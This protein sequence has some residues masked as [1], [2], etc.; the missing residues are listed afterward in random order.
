MPAMRILNSVGLEVELPMILEDDNKGAVDICNSWT[1]G[2]RTHHM[3]KSR[4]IFSES[5]RSKD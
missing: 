1:V 2:G 5:Q 4:C 3:L